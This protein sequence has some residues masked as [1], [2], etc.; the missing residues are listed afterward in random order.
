MSDRTGTAVAHGTC[1]GGPRCASFFTHLLFSAAVA[2][3]GRSTPIDAPGALREPQGRRR[4]RARSSSVRSGSVSAAAYWAVGQATREQRGPAGAETEAR[5]PGYPAEPPPRPK[6]PR[7]CGRLPHGAPPPPQVNPPWSDP[8]AGYP[9]EPPPPVHV[10]P[11][12]HALRREPEARKQQTERPAQALSRL[13]GPP[14]PGAQR[15]RPH[16]LRPASL[17][18]PLS[19]GLPLSL[20]FCRRQFSVFLL[21]AL[22]ALSVSLSLP[23]SASTNPCLYLCPPGRRT[24]SAPWS[25]RGPVREHPEERGV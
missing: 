19:L 1:A 11:R 3:S 5:R 14:D 6:R 17:D 20:S 15:P 12:R 21:L 7:P 25:V 22:S 16:T 18:L 24:Q 23:V 4:P 10:S 8:A 9:A 13:R 2:C